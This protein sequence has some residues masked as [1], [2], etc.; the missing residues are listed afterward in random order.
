MRWV[1][2]TLLI[3]TALLVALA[4]GLVLGFEPIGRWMAEREAD[5]RGLDLEF[6]DLRVGW[7]QVSIHDVSVHLEGVDGV[8]IDLDRVVLELSAAMSPERVFVNGAHVQIK[9]HFDEVVSQLRA[10]KSKY[11]PAVTGAA[12]RPSASMGGG[13]ELDGRDLSVTWVDAVRGGPLQEASGIDVTRRADG[14]MDVTVARIALESAAARLVIEELQAS[15]RRYAGAEALEGAGEKAGEQGGEKVAQPLSQGLQALTAAKVDVSVV[16]EFDRFFERAR[17]AMGFAGASNQP[18]AADDAPASTD[19]PAAGA[20]PT[21]PAAAEP[22]HDSDAAKDA[23]DGPDDKAVGSKLRA[24]LEL[25]TSNAERA[26]LPDAAVELSAFRVA[27]RNGDKT[28]GIGPGRLAVGRSTEGLAIEFVPGRESATGAGAGGG[29]ATTPLAFDLKLP[30]TAKPLEAEL[31]G[32]PVSLTWLGIRDGD[33]GLVGTDQTLVRVDTRV[34]LSA[35]ASE[36]TVDGGG[37]IENLSIDKPWL[38]SETVAGIQIAGDLRGTFAVDRHAAEIKS[39]RIDINGIVLEATA[40]FDRTPEKTTFDLNGELPTTGC[41]HL[42]NSIPKGFAPDLAGFELTGSVGFEIDVHFDSTD[43]NA[44]KAWWDLE[45]RCRILRAPSRF[46]PIRFRQPF[47]REI[48]T[49]DGYLAAITGPGTTDWYPLGEISPYMETAVVVSEDSRFWRHEGIDPKAVSSAIRD[50]LNARRF[51][52]GASTITM[53]LAKNLYLTRAKTLSRKLQ[54]AVLTMLLEQQ[55][56]KEEILE[57]YLNVIEYGPNVYGIGPA[58][59]YYF[60]TTP[61]RLTLGQALY[62]G[63]ILPRPSLSHFEEDGTLNPRWATYLK[64]LMRISHGLKRINDDELERGLAEEVVRVAD[65]AALDATDAAD[66]LLDWEYDATD[67][68]GGGPI[69]GPRNDAESGAFRGGSG[70]GLRPGTGRM[71]SAL[72][73]PKARLPVSPRRLELP[74]APVNPVPP[75]VKPRGKAPS[76]PTTPHGTGGAGGAGAGSPPSPPPPSPPPPHQGYPS[77]PF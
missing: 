15:T 40:K 18:A 31:V 29:T 73:P 24:I 69:D 12:P 76:A 54:E 45:N 41:Q 28:F 22:G 7:S 4:I 65:D 34:G 6:E 72:T 37:S 8:E 36:L 44:T 43:E 71:P 74:R 68:P 5:K 51:F 21:S 61:S 53:Q 50:N 35:D 27:I 39:A 26:L 19:T 33:A 47:E 3:V 10:W 66:G 32:G 13:V 2:R 55:L 56:S 17:A 64:R 1:K 14:S 9:G 52:R 58:A 59:R 11:R 62:I 48:E 77:Q 57:L 25:V 75:Q 38:S 46:L 63:S 30:F 70:A 49:E 20:L 23:S 60:G 16:V 42:L 67:G